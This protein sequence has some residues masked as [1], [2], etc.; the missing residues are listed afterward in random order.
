[1]GQIKAEFS[2]FSDAEKLFHR[3]LDELETTL[4][5]LAADLDRSMA[6]WEGDDKAA[7]VDAHAQWD[8]S[9]RALHAQL[10]LLHKTIVR[11]HRNY[12]SS[13]STNVRMWSA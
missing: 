10:A 8:A 6:R 9:A 4:D 3:A 12:Q 13:S 7:Y 5:E 11:A 1:M 2:A